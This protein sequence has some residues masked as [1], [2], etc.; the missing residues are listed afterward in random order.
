MIDWPGALVTE[1]AEHRCVVVVGAGVSASAQNG[2]GEH[3][4]GWEAFL[5]ACS[6]LLPADPPAAKD[7]AVRL[8]E[9]R[10]FVD[11]AEI[12]GS[13]ILPADFDRLVRARLVDPR[14]EPSEWHRL[15][16]RLDAKVVITLNYD[17]ILD[18]QCMSGQAAASYNVSRYYDSH[19][20]NDLRSDKRLIVKAHGCVSAPSKIILT[21]RGYFAARQNHQSFYAILDA[22][23]LTSTLLFLGCGFNEDPDIHLALE[24]TNIAAKCDHTHYA[25]ISP[26]RPNAVL[27]AMEATF[28]IRFFE[29]SSGRHEEG[30]AA[31]REL[32][33]RVETERY[34]T[35][36]A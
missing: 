17:D 6:D 4:P 12:V 18:R 23:F 14:F 1:L 19:L 22:L 2:N 32:V 30:L 5:R 28:N 29:Y 26:E 16:Q 25:M 7:E 36:R 8:V 10:R 24:N 35:G 11:A 20:L 34:R 9:E 3:P 15:V 31:L 13:Q 27:A 21:R 33:D